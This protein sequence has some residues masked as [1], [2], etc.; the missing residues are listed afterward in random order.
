MADCMTPEVIA[1]YR[2][3]QIDFAVELPAVEDHLRGCPACQEALRAAASG[4]AGS[5]ARQLLPGP[6]DDLCPEEDLLTRY[7]LGKADAADAE[8][9][10]TH[11]ADCP[12]CAEDVA[13]L[14]EFQEEM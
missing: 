13:S 11:L 1:R 3:G 2:A 14:R 5:L 12:R 8:A 9:V 10:E 4:A 7:A 6:E